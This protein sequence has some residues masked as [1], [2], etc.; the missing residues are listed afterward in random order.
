MNNYTLKDLIDELNQ[1]ILNHPE[2]ADSPVLINGV[3][4]SQGEIEEI[5]FVEGLV[6]RAVVINSDIMSG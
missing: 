5:N 1:I 4:G 2:S 6:D 3:Y